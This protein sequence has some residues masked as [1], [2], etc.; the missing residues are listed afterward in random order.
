MDRL[1][2]Y[3]ENELDYMRR[4]FDAFARTHPQA[5]RTLAVT[6]GKSADPDIQRLSDSLALIASRLNQR[7]DDAVP[8]IALDLLRLICP[9]F[10]LGSPSY[11]PIKLEKSDALAGQVVV[12]KGTE[13]DFLTG[14]GRSLCRYTSAATVKIAPLSAHN[15]HVQTAPFPFDTPNESDGFEAALSLTIAPHD[16][17]SSFA[18][19]KVDSLPLYINAPP[20]RKQRIL[21]VLAGGIHGISLS[22]N[23][24]GFAH[25]FGPEA[26]KFT[27]ARSDDTYLPSSGIPASGFEAL[28]DFIAYPDQAYFFEIDNLGDILAQMPAGTITLRIFVDASA[29]KALEDVHSEDLAINVVPLINTYSD[30]TRPL[31]Y[32]YQR[33]QVPLL[34]NSA[35][36]MDV[37]SLQISGID[38]LTSEGNVSLPSMTDPTRRQESETPVW[39]ERHAHGEFNLARLSVSFSIP[40]CHKQ[41][42]RDIPDEM[43]IVAKVLCSNGEAGTRPKPG[44]KCDFQDDA[45]A[46]IP[47]SL[48]AEPTTA[49]LPDC[50]ADQQWEVL[51][52][53]NANFSTLF[54]AK[55][56]KSSL[57]E[58]LRICAPNHVREAGDAVWDVKVNQRVAPMQVDGSMLLAAGSEIEVTLDKSKLPI[59]SHA[60]AMALN[61]FIGCFVSFDRFFQLIV[62]ERGHVQPLRV[63]PRTHGMALGG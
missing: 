24:S 28:R 54:E 44:A 9:M 37:V 47:F 27:F 40:H 2:Q 51:S 39:Q 12:R 60:F 57:V 53:L 59:A 49:I 7:M 22:E 36:Q 11:C 23:N 1:L 17:D 46:G 31:R 41:G 52:L 58:A 19:L 5:A 30:T 8:E 32:N 3:Y 42:K 43:D 10:L 16:P 63:F 48:V 61:R 56:P 15:F 45:L 55:D 4:A 38:Q 62:R 18:D 20:G 6:A 14:E 50:H 33:V 29:A 13:L 35:D 21:N 25:W 26:L 34:P